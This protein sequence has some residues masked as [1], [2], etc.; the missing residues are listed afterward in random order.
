MKFDVSFKNN[1]F[2]KLD[3]KMVTGFRRQ[4]IFIGVIEIQLVNHRSM[5]KH[6]SEY[7]SVRHAFYDVMRSEFRQLPQQILADGAPSR[8]RVLDCNFCSD[9]SSATSD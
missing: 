5:V 9:V 7:D 8:S 4:F 6:R 1:M 2:T 3:T